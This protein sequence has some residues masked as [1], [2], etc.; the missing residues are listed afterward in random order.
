MTNADAYNAI[1][2]QLSKVSCD[3]TYDGK[4]WLDYIK[5]VG[6]AL[7]ITRLADTH[8]N[9]ELRYDKLKVDGS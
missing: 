8:K 4:P 3:V 5:D 9:Y 7:K 6:F 1:T 2:K